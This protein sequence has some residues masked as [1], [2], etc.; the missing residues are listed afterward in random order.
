MMGHRQV[1]QAAL[2]DPTF[3]AADVD[4]VVR[5]ASDSVKNY[6]SEASYGQH[7]L[8][9]TVT[10]T[11]LAGL[12]ESTQEPIETRAKCNLNAVGSSADAATMCAP[13]DLQSYHNLYYVMPY[14]PGNWMGLAY[15]GL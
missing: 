1:E 5:T 8:D 7:L 10:S 13:Y 2:P 9:V 15:I 3:T 14:N 12:D 4:S 6:Y 11:W